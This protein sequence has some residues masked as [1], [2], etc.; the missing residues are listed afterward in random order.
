MVAHYE[1]LRNFLAKSVEDIIN[2]R[3]FPNCEPI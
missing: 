1:F 2:V 3:D